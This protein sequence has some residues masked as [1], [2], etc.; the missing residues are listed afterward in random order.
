MTIQKDVLKPEYELVAQ[1]QDQSIRYL[2]HG[3]PSD[4]VR[5]HYHEEYELHYIE[6][7]SGKVF[8]GDYMGNFNAKSLILIGPN[9]PHNWISDIT[10]EQHFEL[11]DRV[12]NFSDEFIKKSEQTFPEMQSI[13]PLWERA[14]YG[15]EFL[16]PVIIEQASGLLQE[17]SVCSGFRRLTLFW[18]LIE[19]L[20]ACEDYKLLSASAYL[21]KTDEKILKQLSQAVTYIIENYEENIKQE[22]VAQVVNMSAAYFSRIFRKATGHNFVAFV[23][24]I[25][26]NKVCE[27]LAHTD[28]PIT[29]ICFKVGYSNI[30]NFNRRFF[31]QK[32]MTPSEYRKVSSDSLYTQSN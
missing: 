1:R 19:K 32:K 28:M 23:N 4:L 22:E 11:R 15:I 20:A 17:I 10:K 30:A 27:L 31:D 25:R 7:T 9:L 16:D 21:S 6:Q 26:I 18:T 8:V 14:K 5:W 13:A 24:S 2:Q 3:Y 29:D 12:V